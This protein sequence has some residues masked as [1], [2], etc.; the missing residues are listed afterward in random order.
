MGIVSAVK[1]ELREV[2]ALSIMYSAGEVKRN[3]Q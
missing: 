2:G 1:E 3:E